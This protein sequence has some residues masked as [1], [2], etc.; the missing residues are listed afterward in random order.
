MRLE[1]TAFTQRGTAL[2]ARLAEEL[3]E[4]AREEKDVP[5][6]IQVKGWGC[7]G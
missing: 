3:A 4:A 2:A 1:L 5:S 6:I 7:C